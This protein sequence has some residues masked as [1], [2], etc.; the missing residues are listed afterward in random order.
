MQSLCRQFRLPV[1]A[2]AC[3]DG[4]RVVRRDRTMA[5]PA[6]SGPRLRSDR[7]GRVT[8][9][10]VDRLVEARLHRG[11]PCPQGPPRGPCRR[12]LSSCQ[13]CVRS[14]PATSPSSR[15]ARTPRGALSYRHVFTRGPAARH[16][17]R[18]ALAGLHRARSSPRTRAA[19]AP[20][21]CR[22]RRHANIL[23]R[24]LMHVCGLN[25]GLL[26]RRL[27]GVGTPRSLQGRA[28]ALI[29]AFSRFWSFVLRHPAAGSS[30]PARIDRAA[31]GYQ[32]LLPTLQT[33]GSTTGC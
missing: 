3:A 8:A 10:P 9:F 6:A 1:R 14:P 13:H 5:A 12:C 21:T 17:L 20:P 23:K 25:P 30:D 22:R 29:D 33:A 24:L 7:G 18:H 16:R 31:P 28:W 2:R 27:T 26:M 15:P 4:G 11:H 32:P 19:A